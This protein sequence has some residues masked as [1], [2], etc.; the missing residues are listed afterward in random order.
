MLIS[1]R[2]MSRITLP[3]SIFLAIVAIMPAFAQIAGYQ[4]RIFTILRRYLLA[5]SRGCG[6]WILC[7]R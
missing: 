6:T 3:G 2:I 4:C 1:T 7:N 5:Y